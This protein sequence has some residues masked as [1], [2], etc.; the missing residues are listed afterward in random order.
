MP[1]NAYIHIPFCKSKCRYCS[2]VSV[3]GHNEL[4]DLYTEAV[5][6][7]TDTFYRGETLKTIYFGG[8]TPSA[9]SIENIEKILR[10]FIFIPDYCDITFEMNPDDADIKYLR[11]LRE[12]GVNRISFGAQ[13]FNNDILRLIGRRHLVNQTINAVELAKQAGFK[14]INLD[15][16]YGLP[17]QTEEMLNKDL[18]II[19]D[20]RIQHI[21]TYGLKIE[22]P[23]YFYSNPPENLPDDDAQAQ[24]Y[25]MINEFLNGKGFKRYE[26]SNFAKPG[27]ESKHNINY[28]NNREYYGFGAAAHGYECGV[29]YSNTNDIEEYIKYP[30]KRETEHLVTPKEKFEEEIFLGFRREKGINTSDIKKKYYIDFDDKYKS[31]L[32]KYVPKYITQTQDGYKFTLE[33]VLLS[34]NILAEFIEG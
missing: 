2:F 25:L 10:K 12:I 3:S 9:L 5:C 23:S 21:S 1:D 32:E 16:M 17:T 13:S 15:L 29:R 20:L 26:I 8:G 28:W 27:F 14:N 11:K 19:T 31:V 30:F 34:N 6:K 18:E 7:E 24:M 33:G 22:S 4:K